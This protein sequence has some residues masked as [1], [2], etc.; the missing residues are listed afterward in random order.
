M[1]AQHVLS[2]H[3]KKNNRTKSQEIYGRIFQK[4]EPIVYGLSRSLLAKTISNLCKYESAIV[5][6]NLSQ[7]KPITRVKDPNSHL[8]IEYRH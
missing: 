3:R 8:K 1:R 4:P 5:S 7:A 2:Y 6:S